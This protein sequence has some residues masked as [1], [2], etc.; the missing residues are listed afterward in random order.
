MRDGRDCVRT[1]SD[2]AQLYQRRCTD[3]QTIQQ[4]DRV[5]VC[6]QSVIYNIC[7]DLMLH[8]MR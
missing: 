2:I 8:V 3:Q 5:D 4:L 6:D 1:E 7:R